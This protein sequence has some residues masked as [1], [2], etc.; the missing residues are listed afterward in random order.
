M[1]RPTHADVSLNVR[2]ALVNKWALQAVKDSRNQRL[3]QMKTNAPAA[4][5]IN[6]DIKELDRL[7]KVVQSII[8]DPKKNAPIYMNSPYSSKRKMNSDWKKVFEFEN[9]PAVYNNFLFISLHSNATGKPINTAANGADMYLATN[10][11]YANYSNLKYGNQFANLLLDKI[12]P[13]GIKRNKIHNSNFVVVREHNVPGVLTEN[14]FHT[15]KSDRSKLMSDTFLDKLA[16][17]YT[18]AIIDY[19]AGL[20]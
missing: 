16:A 13:L 6:K 11:T 1:T 20:R 3:E 9:D 5:S 18:E 10:G 2:A 14:G 8:D 12:H 17:A 4:A 15:N 7:L 19:F